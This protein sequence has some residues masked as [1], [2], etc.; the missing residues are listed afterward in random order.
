MRVRTLA[1]IV[2]SSGDA[3]I[4]KTLDGVITSWNR[5]AARIYGYTAAEAIGQ[6]ISMLAGGDQRDE[7]GQLLERLGR[8]EAI[9]GLEAR[10]LHK[11]GHVIEVSL[12]ISPIEDEAGT[13]VGASTI[14]RDIT[15]RRRTEA[16]LRQAQKMEAI[17]S[18]AAGIAHDFNNIL[19]VIRT[20]GALLLR[21]LDD[22]EL[23]ADVMQID[24]AARRAAELTHQLLAFSSQ[25]VLR[26][27]VTDLNVAVEDTLALLSR[28]IGEN[29]QIECD[30]DPLIQS[31]VV[32][33]GQLV[34]VIMNLAVN[35]R[36]AMSAGGTLRIHTANVALDELFASGH[37]G[38]SPGPFTL[39]QVTDSGVG[40]DEETKNRVFDPFFTTKSTG[41]GLGLA[42][43]Y[44]IVKQSA[45]HIWI[46]SEA[47]MG[48]TFK[49]YFP[50]GDAMAVAPAAPPEVG[51]LDGRET[52]LLVED[53]AAVRPLVALALRSFGYTVLE[54]SNGLEAIAIAAREGEAIALLLTDVVMPDM[55]GRELA[56]DIHAELPALHVLYTSGYPADTII[57]HGITYEGASYLEKPYLPEDLARK[58]RQILDAPITT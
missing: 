46:Y 26:P 10:R 5:G 39:L 7:F 33:H 16:Q 2:E 57:R 28:L 19:M 4:G 31:I 9:D 13:I 20:C 22:E 47:G 41:T 42:T 18:L 37:A 17:G 45:G 21:R 56:E 29:I 52:I 27:A 23:R 40:M 50:C 11:D 25:Q 15:S 58:V 30:L 24:D 34:Q 12:T 14:A 43:V 35:A 36:D 3:I 6:P 54:A 49:L 51:S 38:I 44:G 1:A 8:G 55:N 32:D 48:T 53:H